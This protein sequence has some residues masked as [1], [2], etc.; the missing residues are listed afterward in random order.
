MP[1]LS[2]L[3]ELRSCLLK[4]IA[5]ITA[6]AAIGCYYSEAIFQL[7][8]YPIRETS[9]LFTLMGTTPAEAFMIKLKLGAASGF[10]LSLPYTFFQLWCF[11]APALH[12]KERRF[13]IPFVAGCSL[14]F[15]C[16]VAF[17]FFVVLPLAFSFFL[18]EYQSIGVAANLKISDYLDFAIDS[19]L[20]FG[21]VFE[22]PIITLFLAKLGLITHTFLIRHL[23]ISI[24]IIFFAAAI[25]TP[26]DVMSQ[27][28]LAV[29]LLILYAIC[30]LVAYLFG[31]RLPVDRKILSDDSSR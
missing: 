15:L 7:V 4:I 29:P 19:L 26:P 14:C 31:T 25:L 5:G 24:V 13:A 2:H 16:G 20:I 12:E 28:L 18:E 9:A 8:T 11:I 10:L 3:A 17:C 23:R 21:V 27:I 30:I 6:G 1:L 22:L